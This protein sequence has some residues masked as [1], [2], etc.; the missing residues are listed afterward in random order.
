MLALALTALLAQAPAAPTPPQPGRWLAHLESPGGKLPFEFTLERAADGAWRAQIRNEPELLDVPRVEWSPEPRELTLDFPHYDSRITA[1]AAAD[2]AK[3]SGVWRKRKS[4]DKW[5]TMRF[6]AQLLAQGGPQ[7]TLDASSSRLA[8]A[9]RSDASPEHKFFGKW[10]AQFASDTVPSVAVWRPLAPRVDAQSAAI[11]SGDDFSGTFLT[12]LGDYR[13]LA[14]RF[15]F[16]AETLTLS[17]FDGAHAFLFR[18]TLQPDGSLAGDFWSGESWHD[19]W[20]AVRDE[21]ARLPDPFGLTQL[22]PGVKLDELAFPDVDG[23]PHRLGDPRFAGKARIVQLL[24]TWCPNCY[25]ETLYLRELHERYAARG[26]SI[27]G[28]AFEVTG[29]FARDSRQV[30]TYARHHQL[31]Y[32]L[33]VAGMSDKSKAALRFPLLDKLRAYPTTLFVDARGEVR[34]VHQGFSGPAAGPEHLKLREDFERLIETLLA[35]SK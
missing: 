5:S 28:L 27:V 1:S 29:D 24:G 33:L 18:A 19:T 12:T 26:L 21:Q 3:L 4:A 31:P 20:T 6:S 13:F 30:R 7:Q 16:A 2:G 34:A 25:D 8:A 10:R 14:G 35:E 15:D 17:C 11:A 22:K 9:V 23:V 32:P